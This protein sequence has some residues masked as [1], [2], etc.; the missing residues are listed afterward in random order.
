MYYMGELFAGRGLDCN[1]RSNV[2]R[3]MRASVAE[4]FT[5]FMDETDEPIEDVEHMN[6]GNGV[7]K[8]PM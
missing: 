3:D 7:G 1:I 6:S 5:A 8:E 2:I 4:L